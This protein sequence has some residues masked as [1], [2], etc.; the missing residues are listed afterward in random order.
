MVN[1][2]SE[3]SWYLA[4]WDNSGLCLNPESIYTWPSSYK[5]TQSSLS[6][7]SS[8]KEIFPVPVSSVHW[9]LSAVFLSPPL[10]VIFNLLREIQ[11][12]QKRGH[13]LS[14]KHLKIY[15]GAEEQ[16]WRPHA[17]PPPV[18]PELSGCRS[19]VEDG[20]EP[21]T[22]RHGDHTA[23]KHGALKQPT[24]HPVPSSDSDKG[25]LSTCGPFGNLLSTHVQGQART[26]PNSTWSGSIWSCKNI[27]CTTRKKIPFIPA[28]FPQTHR[29]LQSF[30]HLQLCCCVWEHRFCPA[31]RGGGRQRRGGTAFFFTRG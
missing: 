22:G 30:S 12:D 18:R 29:P 31:G 23:G 6:P 13:L 16:S 19:A 8:K 28:P 5:K 2:F 11:F 10:Q 14:M 20:T 9:Q 3:W 25:S 24:A 21:A 4:K 7:D 26:V 1:R 17:K 15:W 27:K